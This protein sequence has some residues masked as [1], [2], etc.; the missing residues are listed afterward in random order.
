M[1]KFNPLIFAAALL[2]LSSCQ[3][4]EKEIIKETRT[5]LETRYV[6]S[7]LT[8]SDPLLT[9]LTSSVVSADLVFTKDPAFSNIDLTM[10]MT[11]QDILPDD[12]SFVFGSYTDGSALYRNNDGTY[13]LINNLERDYSIARIILN[14]DLQPLEGDY[15]V[16]SI[17]TGFTAQCSG[18]SITEEEHGFG[19]YYLSG[20]EWGGANKGVYLVDPYRPTSQASFAQRI[21][22][23]GEWSTEN[24]VVIGKDAY[25]SETVVFIGDDDSNNDYP[26]G[27]FGMYVGG[28]GDLSN[29]DLYVLRG[30][31]S[32][33]TAPGQGGLKFEMGMA[34]GTAYDAEWVKV[35]E[36]TINELNQEAIDSSAIGFQRIEDIDWQ[37]GSADNQRR[38]FFCVTGRRN[39]PALADRGTTFGRIYMVELNDNDP[40]GDCRITCILD[41]DNPSGIAAGF[42]SP[43]NI[44]VTENYVYIQEDPNGYK[45]GQWAKLYQYDIANQSLRTVLECNEDDAQVQQLY[46]GG[47]KWEITGMI[48]V[49]DV[50]SASTPTFICGIQ[51]HGWEEDRIPTAVRAD[52]KKFFDPTAIP[53]ASSD[54]EGSFLFKIEGLAR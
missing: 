36:R 7:S 25:P 13:T 43:D 35:S 8:V 39:N 51:V 18:S 3:D 17:A 52:G 44:V 27:H 32:T 47:G 1:K 11:S 46:G 19:P 50:I 42:N 6:D 10:I 20:G 45:P 29:G 49:T 41:G 33:E 16:N 14:Q 30:K 15:I 23:M 2:A 24:A 9:P 38:L 34:E 37:R 4:E 12:S 31:N 54:L 22:A 40:E 21:P 53:E 28:R 26:E 48:D 5:V